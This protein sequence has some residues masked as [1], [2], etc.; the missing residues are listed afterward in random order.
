MT[1]TIGIWKSDNPFSITQEFWKLLGQF[2]KM[3]SIQ[4][5]FSGS[6]KHVGLLI[7]LLTL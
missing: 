7:I 1:V 3:R 4:E 2:V 6:L 5:G